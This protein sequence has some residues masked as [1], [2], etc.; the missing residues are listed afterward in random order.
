VYPVDNYRDG[1]KGIDAVCPFD[2]ASDTRFFVLD[3]A[4]TTLTAFSQVVFMM[5]ASR[6]ETCMDQLRNKYR[7]L[8]L[9]SELLPEEC[10]RG[11]F[12]YGSAVANSSNEE[13]RAFIGG[14]S[15]L[16]SGL[17]LSGPPPSDSWT[18][19]LRDACARLATG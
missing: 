4:K 1:P 9:R 5:K 18:A 11:S 17:T 6:V 12:V 14:A 15:G 8:P 10:L 3:G 19:V 13:I 16:L 7:E 2:A